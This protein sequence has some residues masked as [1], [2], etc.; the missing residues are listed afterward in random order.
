MIKTIKNIEHF[1]SAWYTREE[2][3]LLRWPG[4]PTALLGT[5]APVLPPPAAP[6]KWNQRKQGEYM[7][8]VICYARVS[9]RGQNLERQLQAFYDLGYTDEQIVIDRASGS[10]FDR[11]GYEALKQKTLGLRRGDT[12]VVKELDRLGRNKEGIKRELEYWKECGV[13]VQIIDI[14]TTMTKFPE[15]MEWIQNVVSNILIEI[16]SAQA[17]Q[18]RLQ[19]RRRMREGIEAMPIVDGKRVSRKTHRPVGRPKVQPKNWVQFYQEYT[20]R[21]MTGKECCE[22]MGI[23]LPTFYRL[24]R[25][26]E[27]SLQQQA[28]EK[29]AY[30]RTQLGTLPEEKR[31]CYICGGKILPNDVIEYVETNRG[32]TLFVHEKCV[33]W[34]EDADG[35][36]E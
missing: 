24:K 26:Y 28:D 33:K 23:S 6:L 8:K 34:K 11:P 13:K 22:K 27:Q 4:R 12:L 1:D 16:L 30:I 20:Q 15:G 25:R 10:T 29:Q 35:K 7:E 3:G 21:K 31:K 2:Q 14:P 18:E 36:G 32:D 9:S 19:I 17:E 5:G